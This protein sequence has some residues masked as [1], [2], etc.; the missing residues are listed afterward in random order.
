MK[1]FMQ[2][3]WEDESGQ[4]LA[5]YAILLGLITV[6]LIAAIGFFSDAILGLFEEAT[7]ELQGAGGGG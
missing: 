1:E 6:F 3:F 4:D 7:T 5:E 2:R